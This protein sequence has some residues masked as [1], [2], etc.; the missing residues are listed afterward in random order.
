M[1]LAMIDYRFVVNYSATI[2]QFIPGDMTGA[3]QN[4][5]R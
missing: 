1:M 3:Y 2:L 4:G 5:H